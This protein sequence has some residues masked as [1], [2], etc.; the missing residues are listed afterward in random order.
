M[1][2]QLACLERL[3]F[4]LKLTEL[5]PL[6]PE[7]GSQSLLP[8][9]RV[10]DEGLTIEADLLKLLLFPGDFLEKSLEFVV[11]LLKLVAG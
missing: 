3:Y 10:S 11:F 6:C 4:L 5:I 7:S 9:L 1:F 2:L 8:G